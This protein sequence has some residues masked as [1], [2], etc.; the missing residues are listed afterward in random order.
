VK[1]LRTL[2]F[3]Y[4]IMPAILAALAA[5]AFLPAGFMST[6]G[7][8][9]MSPTIAMCSPDKM[10]R[11]RVEIPGQPEPR[12]H[13]PRCEHCLAP[14]LGAPVA[15]LHFSAPALLPELVVPTHAQLATSPLLRAQEA[16]APPHA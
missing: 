1:R 16:R 8:D 4:W 15:Q 12:E 7:A 11:E 10:R 14:L 5:R 2:R 13:R 6:S 9:G 3:R